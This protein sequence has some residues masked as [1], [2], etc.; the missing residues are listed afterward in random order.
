MKTSFIERHDNFLVCGV[1]GLKSAG[2]TSGPYLEG[3]SHSTDAAQI[4][5][6]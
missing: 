4:D 6:K 2:L 1:T 3:C 5:E